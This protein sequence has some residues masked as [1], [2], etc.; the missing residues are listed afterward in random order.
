MHSRSFYLDTPDNARK[1][2]MV[3][4]SKH[5]SDILKKRV[6]TQPTVYINLIPQYLQFFRGVD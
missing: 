3:A 1:N 6:H 5:E 2:D 4:K